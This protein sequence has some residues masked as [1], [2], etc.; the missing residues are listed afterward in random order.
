MDNL[1]AYL[2]LTEVSHPEI[3]V[4]QAI[5]ETGHFK[6]RVFKRKNNLFG[7]CQN[8]KF[9]KFNHWTECVDKYKS[10]IQS[11]MVKK[12]HGCYYAFLTNMGYA[13]DTKYVSKLK[14]IKLS[15]CI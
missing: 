1:V 8:G 15:N 14:G 6:S 2:N 9:M 12:Y 10:I 7:M 13:E 4:R 3:V 5:L 11:K